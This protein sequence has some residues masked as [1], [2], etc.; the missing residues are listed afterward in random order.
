MSY[1]RKILEAL[2]KWYKQEVGEE[3]KAVFILDREGKVIDSLTS[4]SVKAVEDFV[5]DIIDTMGLI[6]KKIKEVF[7]LGTF[8]VGT[9]D[10]DEHRFIFCEAG[11]DQIIVTILDALTMADPVIPYVYIAAEKVAR[12]FDGRP[13][14]PVIPK[15]ITDKSNKTAQIIKRKVNTLQK[16]QVP[17]SEY[18]YKLALGGDGAVGKTSMIHR[19]L[20]GIFRTD[21]K[22]TI[23]TA[24]T[25]KECEFEGLSKVRFVIWD[26]AGQQQFERIR[27]NYLASS[28]AGI[29]VY[30]ITR[31]N[32][33]DNIKKWYDDF[34]KGGYPD[35]L[36]LLVGN[37]TDLNSKRVISTAEGEKLAKELGISYIETSAMTGENINDAFRMIALQ[38]IKRFFEAKIVSKIKADEIP[39]KIVVKDKKEEANELID[40]GDY[41]KIP[42]TNIWNDKDKNFVPWLE[43]NIDYLNKVL[44]SSLISIER[45]PKEID[46]PIDILAED[47]LGNKVLITIQYN[48]TDH[49]HLG[50]ILSSLAYFDAKKVIWIC[51]ETSL[52]HEKII[53]WLNKNT[54]A[55]VFFYL[56]KF[57]VFTIENSPPTLLFL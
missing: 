48:K 9:F 39:K 45:A 23:G 4:S 15:I 12:I 42:I 10:T 47:K 33:F 31:R 16:V 37:K 57:E 25:K 28:E 14:S 35:I 29:L 20:E 30:D 44:E 49:L 2:L 5:E 19:F 32:T 51:E 26:L 3:L 17:S 34:K 54:P 40:L 8:G 1:D 36:L 18:V 50:K 24:I 21:Y 41:K 43:K 13:V 38:L 53:T 7:K 52:E 55:D 27:K 46:V 11:P 56:V 22:A 6:L